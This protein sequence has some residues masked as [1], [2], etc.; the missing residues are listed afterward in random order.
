MTG[1]IIDVRGRKIDFIP[2]ENSNKV[3]SAYVSKKY[4][5]GDDINVTDDKLLN[6]LDDDE[7]YL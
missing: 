1:V 3:L 5:I 2:D 7:I 6:F 4:N